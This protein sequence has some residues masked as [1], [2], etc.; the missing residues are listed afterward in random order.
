M[1]W[2]LAKVLT[3]GGIADDAEAGK[4]AG[5]Q[6]LI[7]TA[8]S[9]SEDSDLSRGRLGP[10]DAVV[11]GPRAGPRRDRTCRRAG[12]R[13]RARLDPLRGPHRL[14]RVRRPEFRRGPAQGRARRDLDG[15]WAPAR[16]QRGGRR[17][18]RDRQGLPR[19]RARG[20]APGGERRLRSRH[21]LSRRGPGKT[22]PRRAGERRGASPSP[23]DDGDGGG[24]DPFRLP[25][26]RRLPLDPAAEGRS[27]GDGPPSPS[28][29]P[30]PMR[31]GSGARPSRRRRATRAAGRRRSRRRSGPRGCWLTARPTPRSRPGWMP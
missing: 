8:R 27:A 3:R 19:P 12:R 31:P 22:P 2:G 11:H 14:A 4:I 24:L 18:D 16:R 17:A 21:G 20:P 23:V 9:G 28:T 25:R 26:R 1:D 30:W 6:T 15:A 5:E 13:L 10:G 29:R 7:A